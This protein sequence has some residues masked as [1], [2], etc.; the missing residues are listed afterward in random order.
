MRPKG[1]P[2]ELE[3]R[4]VLAVE[5]VLDGYSNGEVADFLGVDASSVRRWLAVFHQDGF[6]GLAA[7]PIPGRPRKLTHTQ[8]KIVVRWLTELPTE[9]DFA[10]E[11]WTAARLGQLIQTEWNIVFNHRYLAH[12]LRERGFSPQK[13]ERVPRE[14]DPEALAAWLDAEW[15]RIK[16]TRAAGMLTWL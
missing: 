3:R 5:R 9:H 6:Q 10:T 2:S 13:P 7:R 4:R 15:V 14:R 1:F 16:K 12:W 11:L 8:E